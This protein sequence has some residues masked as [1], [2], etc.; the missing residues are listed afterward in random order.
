LGV[1]SSTHFTGRIPD[2]ELWSYLSTADVCVDPD[3][4]TEWSNLSTMNKMI[5]YLAFGC[6]IVAFDLR[7][8]RNTA[9]D[10]AV[11]VRDN[12]DKQMAHE[13]RALLLDQDRR[14]AMS[15]R[16]QDRFRKLLAW[17][18]SEETLIAAYQSLLLSPADV[19]TPRAKAILR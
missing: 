9:G 19:T 11:Y 18:N 2:S 8:H 4:L 12:D 5:E 15:A 13:I 7:E 14:G 10:S 6:P 1:D 17:E 16:G 3:P